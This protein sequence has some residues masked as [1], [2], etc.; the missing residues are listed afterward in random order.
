VHLRI[1]RI[2]IIFDRTPGND[3]RCVNLR[4]VSEQESL[5]LEDCVDFGQYDLGRAKL[6]EEMLKP[7]NLRFA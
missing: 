3:Q 1:A 7:Q 4:T 2:A 5:G 6:V